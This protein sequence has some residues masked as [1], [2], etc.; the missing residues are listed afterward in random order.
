MEQI[1]MESTDLCYVYSDG[2]SALKDVNIKIKEG[3]T[4]AILGGN[5]VGKSTFILNLNGILRP[6]SGK[7]IFNGQPLDYSKKGLINIRKEVGIVFQDPDKQ[8]F[9]ASV[10]QDV[11]FGPKNLKLTDSEVKNRVENA[12]EKT[13]ISTLRDRPTH[14]LSF[15]QKKRVAIAGVLAM[16]PKVLV[17][18]EPTAGLD[19]KGIYELMDLLDSLKKKLMISIVI[20]THDIDLVPI[21]CDYVYLLNKGEVAL[22]GTCEEVFKRKDIL[23]SCN[24]RLPRIGHLMEIL[25]DIDGH[26]IDISAM[27]IK[28]ARKAINILINKGDK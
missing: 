14:S 9:S 2:T 6:S 17:L 20:S 23:R 26:D 19:P 16:E 21:Y 10:Y 8:L 3:L 18:D 24:L 1:I 15:G 4:T 27:S 12:L 22:E 11:S 13:G 5:G 28:Q 7:I 25:H